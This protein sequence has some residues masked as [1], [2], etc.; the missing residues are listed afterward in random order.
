MMSKKNHKKINPKKMSPEQE[1]E[2][3]RREY[4]KSETILKKLKEEE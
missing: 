3:W 4:E 2:Y 1:L